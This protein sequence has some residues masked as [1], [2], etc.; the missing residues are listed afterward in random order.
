MY[1]RLKLIFNITLVVVVQ[2]TNLGIVGI[3]PS[4]ICDSQ[5]YLSTAI[6][7]AY[8]P[9]TSIGSPISSLGSGTR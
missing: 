2:L 9:P 5:I 4:A 3:I 1:T 6:N 8:Q 7:Q